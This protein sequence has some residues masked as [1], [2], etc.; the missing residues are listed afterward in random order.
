M[1]KPLSDAAI[2]RGMKPIRRQRHDENAGRADCAADNDHAISGE[3]LRQ[4]A[5]HRHEENDH[6]TD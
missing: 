1:T 2:R 6:P 5:D 3:S 4:R